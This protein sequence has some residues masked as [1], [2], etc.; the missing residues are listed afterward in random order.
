MATTTK[1]F[2]G[3]YET[4]WREVVD[5]SARSKAE[6]FPQVMRI[7]SSGN[8]F[9]RFIAWAGLGLPSTK[10]E[11]GPIA[12]D[13][14][15]QLG[16]KEVTFGTKALGFKC[17][18]EAMEDDKYDVVSQTASAI[19]DSIR[20][21]REI[22]A[23][24][25]WNNVL[26]GDP[27]PMLGFDGLSIVNSAHISRK[28]G[29]ITQS[30]LGTGDIGLGLIESAKYHFR[31]LRTEQGFRD[32][33]HTIK[34]IVIAPD[35]TVEPLLM[36]ILGGTGMQP[37]TADNTAHEL[38]ATRTSLS[39]FS[40]TYLTDLDRTIILSDKALSQP[41]GPSWIDRRKP[42]MTSWDDPSIMG[43][44][45]ATSYRANIFCGIWRG[46]FASGG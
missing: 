39:T 16:T 10:N 3:F 22:D 30:N 37:F 24:Q 45:Y 42:S 15:I 38:G 13:D 27:T 46:I 31:N 18:Y 7:L 20:E 34:K 23:A 17:S 29:G 28:P 41:A 14:P 12:F 6:E 5:L 9:E 33:G 32:T 19:G 1:T 35:A 4:I 26:S 44:C 25:L 8:H 21:G 2:T 11:L 40:Y 36:Q 43:S